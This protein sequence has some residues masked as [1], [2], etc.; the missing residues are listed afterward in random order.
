MK[1]HE[2]LVR[3]EDMTD[4]ELD[5]EADRQDM[6]GDHKHAGGLRFY[7]TSDARIA[8]RARLAEERRQG[9]SNP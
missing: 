5:R 6:L 8:D 2:V 9:T 4:A 3:I 1:A 7:K